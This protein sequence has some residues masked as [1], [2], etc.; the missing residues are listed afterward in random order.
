[1]LQ[2]LFS[3]APLY[4][5]VPKLRGVGGEILIL[6]DELDQGW[7]NTAHANRFVGGSLTRRIEDPESWFA[8][9]RSHIS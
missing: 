2:E 6:L 4:E 8:R 7:D 5:L 1:M 3:L 9:P